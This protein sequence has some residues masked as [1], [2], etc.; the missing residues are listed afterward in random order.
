MKLADISPPLLGFFMALQRHDRTLGRQSLT[1]DEYA[2]LWPAIERGIGFTD[3][4]SLY[5]LCKLLWM[6]PYH[7]EAAFRHIFEEHLNIL[8]AIRAK[9]AV[10]HA[11]NAASENAK[12]TPENPSNETTQPEKEATDSAQE[13]DKNAPKNNELNTTI[14]AEKGMYWLTFTEQERIEHALDFSVTVAPKVTEQTFFFGIRHAPFAQRQVAQLVNNVRLMKTTGPRDIPDWPQ[15]IRRLAQRGYLDTVEKSRRPEAELLLHLLVDTGGSMSPYKA[16]S[17]DFAAQLPTTR[18]HYFH[19]CPVE[20]LFSDS[21]LRVVAAQ[22]ADFAKLAPKRIL[23]ISDAGAARGGYAPERIA[24][25]RNWLH[26]NRRHQ[27]VWLNPMPRA[28][29]ADNSAADIATMIPM[30][31]M[32]DAEMLKAFRMLN[33]GK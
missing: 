7:R 28:R 8:A 26:Q 15:T 24:A 9:D 31:D 30:F 6:K 3:V 12:N 33:N 1:L 23:L 4:D 25:T 27:I 17:N 11:P 32:S 10:S 19:N 21:Q 16:W 22:T 20:Y 14:P 29:W 18:T 13:A 2:T 5:G